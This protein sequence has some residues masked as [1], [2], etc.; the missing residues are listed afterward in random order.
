VAGVA[1]IG[2]A[3]ALQDIGIVHGFFPGRLRWDPRKPSSAKA[4]EGTILSRA[5]ADLSSGVRRREACH[6]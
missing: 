1:D 3:D 2:I 5:K 4:T 6:S